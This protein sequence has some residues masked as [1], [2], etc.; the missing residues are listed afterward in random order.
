[1]ILS[2]LA[3]PRNTIPNVHVRQ[4]T[5]KPQVFYGH[6]PDLSPPRQRLH[7]T[8]CTQQRRPYTPTVALKPS[9]HR[10]SPI[11]R[12]TLRSFDFGNRFFPRFALSSMYFKFFFTIVVI[13]IGTFHMYLWD[14]KLVLFL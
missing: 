10:H 2:G 11:D 9:H 3:R 4:S 14:K 7:D 1:M 5:Q 12:A 13:I 6:I 8:H